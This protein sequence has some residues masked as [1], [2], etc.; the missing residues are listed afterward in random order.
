MMITGVKLRTYG[1]YLNA[2]LGGYKRF[3][4]KLARFRGHFPL[5]GEDTV[6]PVK[7]SNRPDQTRDP[8]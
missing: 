1:A 4:V 2:Q 7:L 5:S 8:T 3:I 6:S